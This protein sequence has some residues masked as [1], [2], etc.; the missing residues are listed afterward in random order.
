MVVYD[1]RNAIPVLNI[2]NK[3]SRKVT[4]VIFYLHKKPQI[5]NIVL[6]LRAIFHE[7]GRQLWHDVAYRQVFSRKVR[8]WVQNIF[9][10]DCNAIYHGMCLGKGHPQGAFQGPK[11]GINWTILI[12]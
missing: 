8:T 6:V 2:H 1:E 7:Q 3:A 5:L 11:R 9:F 12:N 4:Y 10:N